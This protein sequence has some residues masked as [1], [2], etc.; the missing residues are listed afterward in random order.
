LDSTQGIVHLFETNF[1]LNF[2]TELKRRGAGNLR[3]TRNDYF[4]KG[5]NRTNIE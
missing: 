3:A 2:R 5:I 1:K 4:R